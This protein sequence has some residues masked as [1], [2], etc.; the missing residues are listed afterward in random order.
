MGAKQGPV[1]VSN[2]KVVVVGLGY[3]GLPLAVAIARKH[4]VTGLDIDSARIEELRTGHDRTGE[5]ARSELESST[6]ALTGD[7]ADCAGAD[8]Y[9]VTVPTPVDRDN[10]P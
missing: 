2:P 6:L 1:A 5:V 10:R 7:P 8:I 9:I 3:V 4:M